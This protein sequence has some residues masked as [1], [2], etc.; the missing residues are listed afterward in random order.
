MLAG[1][2]L[3]AERLA[4]AGPETE[5]ATGPETGAGAGDAC[6]AA[7]LQSQSRSLR[8]ALRQT[9]PQAVNFGPAEA[10]LSVR[11]LLVHWGNASAAP[12]H[13]ELSDAPPMP[14]K[15]RL[16][17]DSSLAQACLN[18]R[19]RL[20][21]AQAV[22]QTAQWYVAWARGADMAKASNAALQAFLEG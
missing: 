4:E 12:P 3:L 10:E 7:D 21:T 1:Y 19:A 17:L 2:L 9:A 20:G 22:A 18:W 14:E 6:A 11:D 8:G 16:A 5:A 13:W 15:S